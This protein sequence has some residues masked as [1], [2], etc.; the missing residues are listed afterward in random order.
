MGLDNSKYFVITC[1]PTGSGKSSLAKNTFKTILGNVPLFKQFL[2][3]DLVEN[4]DQYKLAIDK[5]ISDFNCQPPYDFGKCD[6][7]H[8][9]NQLLVA[10]KDA[11][12]SVR[13]G[14][15]CQ[16]QPMSCNLLNDKLLLTAMERGEHIVLETTGQ[17]I[18]LWIFEH[19]P[20]LSN[21]KIVFLLFNCWLSRARETQFWSSAEF[22]AAL[23]PGQGAQTCAA[24]T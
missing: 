15:E 17:R 22:H 8:P 18:P 24:L 13:N 21:Y 23:C 4:D 16:K 19:L 9:S 11:Y 14:S 3:D 10:F 7:K 5:I 12:M 20:L 1:G 6:L 2:V